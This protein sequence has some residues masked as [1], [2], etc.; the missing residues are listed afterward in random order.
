MSE[1][2]II[3]DGGSTRLK[4]INTG[5]GLMEGLLDVGVLP[6]G[7][8]SPGDLGSVEP[9]NSAAYTTLNITTISPLTGLSTTTTVASPAGTPLAVGDTIVVTS[10]AL[11]GLIKVQVDIGPGGGPGSCTITIFGS[12]T[13]APQVD[14]KVTKKK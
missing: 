12:A 3:D 8:A 1:P 2:V 4:L 9:V 10:D 13:L 14:V 7:S 11:G 5:K 6:A